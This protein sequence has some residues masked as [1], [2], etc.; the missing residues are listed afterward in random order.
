MKW[1]QKRPGVGITC[2][3]EFSGQICQWGLRRPRHTT[4]APG[5]PA[6]L[7]CHI[8]AGLFCGLGDVL[9]RIAA[10]ERLV[11]AYD[12]AVRNF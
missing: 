8:I 10:G 11:V 4:E 5:L 7:A 3:E 9:G 12:V 1:R 6:P 2:S